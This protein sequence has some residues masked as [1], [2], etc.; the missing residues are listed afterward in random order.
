MNIIYEGKDITGEIDVQGATA[1]DYEGGRADDIRLKLADVSE[2]WARWSPKKGDTLRITEGEY[3]SGIMYLDDIMISASECRLGATSMPPTAREESFQTWEGITFRRLIG[4]FAERYSLKRS[5]HNIPDVTYERVAQ[6]GDYDLAWI[7]K[8]CILEG[9]AFKL[10]NGRLVVYDQQEAEKGKAVRTIEIT[11]N[12]PYEYRDLGYS[13]RSACVVES[14]IIR[15]RFAAPGCTGPTMYIRDIAAGSIAEAQRFA[16][17]LLREQN[18][19]AVTLVV[20]Q[21]L[22]GVYAAGE[23]VEVSGNVAAEGLWFISSVHND[24][25]QG[26]VTLGLRRPL[27]W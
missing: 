27:S 6:Y 23:C 12:T 1:N 2:L 15:G 26:M 9:C 17:S 25:G 24:F 11:N 21:E 7:A 22:D 13:L 16:R 4:D 10:Y 20:K 14:G 18:K 5:L 8:R 19:C 3:D